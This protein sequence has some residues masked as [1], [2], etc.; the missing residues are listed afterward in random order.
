MKVDLLNAPYQTYDFKTVRYLKLEGFKLSDG[1]TS[2]EGNPVAIANAYFGYV[3]NI[4]NAVENVSVQGQPAVKK[5]VNGQLVIEK[6]GK[7]YNALG[8]EL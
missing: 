1:E 7:R 6:D 5:I 4:I 3:E 8:V 2:A